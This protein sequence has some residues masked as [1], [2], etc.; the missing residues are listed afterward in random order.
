[1]SDPTFTRKVYI[2]SR[3][4]AA[5]SKSTS[6][7]DITLSRNLVLPQKCAGFVTDIQ[8]PHSWYVIDA[9]QRYLYFKIVAG[10]TLYGKVEL[11]QGN[12]TGAG[13][14]EAIRTLMT[15]YLSTT[16]GA[17]PSQRFGIGAASC[18]G[19]LATWTSCRRYDIH[20]ITLNIGAG[21]PLSGLWA[22]R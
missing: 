7:F 10:T 9:G 8:I 1:M 5:T 15:A 18:M 3:Q 2:C 4:S 21:S 16:S 22:H 14:G 6:D 11:S 13:L 20:L 17:P 12:Y 19:Q